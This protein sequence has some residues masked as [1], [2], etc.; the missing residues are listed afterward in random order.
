[1][2]I[3]V[4]RQYG[5]IDRTAPEAR[6]EAPRP[7][8]QGYARNRAATRALVDGL[9]DADA[10]VQSMD[11]ASPAKWH[12]AHTTWFFETFVLLPFAPGYR[13][14]D[15]HFNFLFNSYYDAIGERQP[16]PRR[17]LLTRPALRR[18]LD[19]RESVDAAVLRLLEATADR[20]VFERVEL[21]IHH[22]Q[23][24]QELLLT[25]ILHLFA[26]NPL[27]PAY[28]PA[29][30]TTQGSTPRLVPSAPTPAP[31]K[32]PWI[33]V[34]GGVVAIGAGSEGFAFDCERPRHDVLLRPFR[35]ASQPV[36]NKEWQA[37]MQDG[38]YTTPSLWLADG[39]DRVQQEKWAC[40][41]Y[42]RDQQG[43]WEQMTLQ[44]LQLVDPGA[45]VCHVS[46]FEADAYACWAGKRLP[47][48]FEWEHAATAEPKRSSGAFAALYDAVWQWTA[49]AFGPYPGFKPLAGDTGEYNGK[50]MNGQ[51]VL[52]GGSCATPAGHTRA[53]YRNF[54]Q[55]E[56]RWQFSGLRLAED[57]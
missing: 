33:E 43:G 27:L 19:Y 3:K 49:S 30:E 54:F 13:V 47:T 2:G 8:A 6:P 37:F 31:G 55:P 57:S 25:D 22:E 11:D 26:Q 16:R 4:Q 40:P 28:R 51:R 20:A 7:I 5:E 36:L 9:S 45:P 12:L 23:Q 24:H 50:F 44:G 41:L 32:P 53:T 39:W 48:E 42:W 21:G 35:L 14:F 18:V 1:V 15:E 46:F 10:T 52:R 34:P 56:K 29:P 17:G 38:G